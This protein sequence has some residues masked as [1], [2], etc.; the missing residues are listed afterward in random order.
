MVLKKKNLINCTAYILF[1][2]KEKKKREKIAR[3]GDLEEQRGKEDGRSGFL[4]EFTRI[5]I[6]CS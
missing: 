6:S 3:G 1:K 4:F 2:K 5:T